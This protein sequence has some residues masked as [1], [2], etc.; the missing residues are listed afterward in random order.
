MAAFA[1]G[2]IVLVR[3]PFSDLTRTKLR[4]ALVLADAGRGDF[5]LCQITS[6]PYTD[7]RAVERGASNEALWTGPATPAQPSSSPQARAS[8]AE[9]S[10]SS[11]SRHTGRW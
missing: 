6:N 8:S 3:F 11:N 4:P 2:E 5:L 10:P 1:A 9:R 7:P